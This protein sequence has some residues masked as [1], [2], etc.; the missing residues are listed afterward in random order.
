[1]VLHPFGAFKVKSDHAFGSNTIVEFYI[2]DAISGQG[3]SDVRVEVKSTVGTDR[4]NID[5]TNAPVRDKY[6]LNSVMTRGDLPC[7]D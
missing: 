6:V 1:M 7:L 3:F 4:V 5:R 2:N